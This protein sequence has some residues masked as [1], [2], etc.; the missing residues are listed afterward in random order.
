MID[1]LY[2]SSWK[3]PER[4]ENSFVDYRINYEKCNEVNYDRNELT[5]WGPF[6]Y[7]VKKKQRK[8]S[9]LSFCDPTTSVFVIFCKSLSLIQQP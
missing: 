4:C 6:K 1:S 5:Q 9:H 3:I 2:Y 7:I 8:I